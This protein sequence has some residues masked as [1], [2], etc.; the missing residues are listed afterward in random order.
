WCWRHVDASL[1]H[2][3]TWRVG[4]HVRAPE[5]AAAAEAR[6]EAKPVLPAARRAHGDRGIAVGAATIPR[7]DTD[8]EPAEE[9]VVGAGAVVQ[10]C[11]GGIR[12]AARPQ[13]IAADPEETI[14]REAKEE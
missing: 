14:W 9:I 4:S 8:A 1:D 7:L 13:T 12:C 10:R 6:G 11:D 2:R 5:V 3:R